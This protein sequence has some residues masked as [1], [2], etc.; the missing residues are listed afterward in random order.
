[1]ALRRLAQSPVMRSPFCRRAAALVLVLLAAGCARGGDVKKLVCPGNIVAPNVDAYALLR[2]GASDS[3][4]PQDVRFGAQIVSL[5]GSC[6]RASDGGI[7][8]STR[9]VFLV[10]RNDPALRQ[11]DFSYFIAIAD[12][13]KNVLAKQIF[14]VHVDFGVR[15]V[16]MRITDNAAE[17]LALHDTRLGG[18]YGVIVGMQLT[19]EQVDFNRRLQNPGGGEPPPPSAVPPPTPFQFPTG[20]GPQGAPAPAPAPPSAA[21]PPPASFKFPTEK[22]Q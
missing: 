3:A 11:V 8:V 14:P 22:S 7:D 16:Q 17:H 4:G 10:A 15:Q 18:Q 9:I 13:Q 19:R 2:D 6:S 5:N 21:A 12:A 1:M 20:K